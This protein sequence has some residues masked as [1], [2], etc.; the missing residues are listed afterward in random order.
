[1]KSAVSSQQSAI[2]DQQAAISS[3]QL[4]RKQSITAYR[5]LF[6]AHCLLL[7]ASCSLP[8]LEPSE[9]TESR[10][11]VKEFYSYHFGNDMKFSP[12]NLKLREKYLTPE[13]T[14]SLQ[15][16]QTENDVFTTNTT[17]FPKAFRTG[18]CEIVSPDKTLFNIVFFWRDDVRSEQ[19]EIQIEIVKKDDEWLI[20][21]IIN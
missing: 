19:Q 3:R 1:M 7:T 5:I 10:G 15:S 12:E 11:V 17:D 9:C 8:N 6:T 2:S 18:E 16:L 4:G 21:K 14:A 13:F 20:S